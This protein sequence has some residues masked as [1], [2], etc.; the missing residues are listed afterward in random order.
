[1]A[2]N[3]NTLQKAKQLLIALRIGYDIVEG[4]DLLNDQQKVIILKG[5]KNY[6]DIINV[7]LKNEKID[8]LGLK[9]L[10]ESFL[11]KWNEGVS[12]DVELFWE[13]IKNENID[14]K[15]KEPLRFA[16][17]KGRFSD[18]HKGMQVRKN[19]QKLKNSHYLKNSYSDNEIDK[20]EN[21]IIADEKKRYELLKS[22]LIK[23]IIPKSK[24]LTFG[25]S[26]AYFNYCNL[27]LKYFS[28]N[29]TE[30]LFKMLEEF[31]AK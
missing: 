26:I 12:I 2:T 8:S 13:K 17:L 23:K 9:S 10:T 7:N 21:I 25:D 14:F 28:T 29:D 19:W 16:L 3:I 5:L 11:T 24:F 1:M 18:V 4:S 30:Y 31:K 20:I 15:R 6:E 27:F 22:C